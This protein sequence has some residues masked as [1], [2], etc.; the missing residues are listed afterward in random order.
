MYVKDKQFLVNIFKRISK[1]VETVNEKVIAHQQ[2]RIPTEDL[3]A[4]VAMEQLGMQHE[5]L[6][7]LAM[8]VADPEINVDSLP[9]PPKTIIGFS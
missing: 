3:L 2:K 5:E 8:L 7:L 1:S 4:T 6:L 9:E